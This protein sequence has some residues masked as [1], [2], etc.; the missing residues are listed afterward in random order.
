MEALAAVRPGSGM[1][2]RGTGQD[3]G[4]GRPCLRLS[5]PGRP[6]PPYPPGR[7]GPRDSGRELYVSGVGEGNESAG[8]KGEVLTLALSLVPALHSDERKLTEA[9]FQLG[10]RISMSHEEEPLGTGQERQS[11]QAGRGL[12]ARKGKVT[13][14]WGLRS[15]VPGAQTLKMMVA[16]RQLASLALARDLLCE[17]ADPFSSSTVT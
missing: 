4:S 13:L 12:R 6:A 7:R 15:L 16:G 9:S 14:G 17:T 5:R 3:W 1:V 2:G 10:I 11:D 8:A